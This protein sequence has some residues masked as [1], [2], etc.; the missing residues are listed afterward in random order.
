VATNALAKLACGAAPAAEAAAARA[1]ERYDSMPILNKMT[2]RVTSGAALRGEDAQAEGK[3]VAREYYSA[4]L[5]HHMDV[6][7]LNAWL[8]AA[9]ERKGQPLPPKVWKELKRLR[10]EKKKKAQLK[11]LRDDLE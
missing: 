11:W 4:Q 9:G 3:G 8:E 7:Q 2:G 5:E 6:R 1:A 10:D